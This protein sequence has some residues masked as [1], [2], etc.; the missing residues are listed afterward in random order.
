MDKM[1]SV[2]KG[3]PLRPILNSILIFL[4]A[5]LG[6]SLL[7]LAVIVAIPQ[8]AIAEN[9]RESAE[10]FSVHDGFPLLMD[11]VE[12]SRLD[13]YADIAL[14]DVIYCADSAHPF[15]SMIAAPYYRNDGQDIR[16]DYHA[17]VFD[18]AVPN[19]EYSRYWHGSQV[20]LRPLLMLT[21]I[22]GCRAV[23]FALLLV[24]NGLL[25]WLLVCR[26]AWLPLITYF[27]ALVVVQFWVSA[28][29][30]EY[31]MVLLVI[32]AAC[33]L[34]VRW[35][36]RGEG[37]L[38]AIF[39]V[40]GVLTC[41]ID[42]LTA[43]T[44]A[45]TV[46]A[47]LALMLR[48]KEGASFKHELLRLLKWGCG[49]LISYAATFAVKWVLAYAA[50]GAASWQNTMKRAALRIEGQTLL[51][52]GTVGVV[53]PFT[54]LAR[55]LSCLWPFTVENASV[56][57]VLLTAVIVLLVVCAALYLFRGD[58]VKLPY[59]AALVLV[60]LVPYLRYALIYS[61]AHVH[62][63]FTYRAQMAS[64]MVLI[65]VCVHTLY[66]SPLWHRKRAKKKGG[67]RR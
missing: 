63:F 45:F 40:S 67:G 53:T 50:S 28:F 27:A 37:R 52:D 13:N 20:L 2:R 4:A 61:H 31:I 41:F 26:R 33:I 19:N 5:L 6:C 43:E 44:L 29:T 36:D 32:S 42:F 51:P 30:L 24:L 64:V 65:A 47:I 57:S 60:G 66:H 21:D 25:A 39:I 18:G 48:E 55:N 49:W 11:G 38:T 62:Y 14:L 54:A 10:Y 9:S 35:L 59:V 16:A 7:L 15:T 56:T 17:A 3:A 8:R 12:G 58:S 34:V 22:Q 46:P 23:L 1:I